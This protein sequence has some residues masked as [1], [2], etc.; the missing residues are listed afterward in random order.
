MPPTTSPPPSSPKPDSPTVRTLPAT[1]H[2]RYLVAR[3]SSAEPR[4]WLVGFH[5]YG[6][7]AEH[8]LDALSAVPGAAAWLIVSVQGLHRF[9]DR[10]REIV[11]SWMT[12]QDR[13]QAIA[14]NVAYVDAVLDD[15]ER[16]VGPPEALVFAGFSQ[17][18][19]MAYRAAV[20]GARRCSA[21]LVAGGDLPPELKTRRD[22]SW[23][24][25]V[26]CAGTRDEFYAPGVFG[27]DL[28]FFRASGIDVRAVRFEGGHEWSEAVSQAAGRLLAECG[29]GGRRPSSSRTGGGP[30]A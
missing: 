2:G 11:A 23:P 28:E 12:S 30:A 15:V 10:T 24:A 8:Q 18:A 19:A 13:D 21:V 27:R 7:A 29:R 25:V 4:R 9:Y 14:D 5:G 3:P 26:V 1:I 6:Q 16:Q 22:L 17:G 20:L